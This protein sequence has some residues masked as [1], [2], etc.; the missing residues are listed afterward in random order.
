MSWKG[1]QDRKLEKKVTMDGTVTPMEFAEI[2]SRALILPTGCGKEA[3]PVL[4]E[5]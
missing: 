5:S 4:F 2:L 3:E 1:Q